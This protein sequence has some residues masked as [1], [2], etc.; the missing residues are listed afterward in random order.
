[1][2]NTQYNTMYTKYQEGTIT[3][4]EWYTF[5]LNTLVEIMTEN[6]Q[7]FVNL[8]YEYNRP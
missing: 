2:S 1:M 3:P 4:Q 7:I 6:R 8:K 5:C